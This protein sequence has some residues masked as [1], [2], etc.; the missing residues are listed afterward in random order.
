MQLLIFPTLL[1]ICA[2]WLTM[3]RLQ[4]GSFVAPADGPVAFRRD[5]LPLD[6]DTMADLSKHLGALA[7]GVGGERAEARRTAAQLLALALALEPG[8]TAARGLLETF[9]KGDPKPG[10][11][12]KQLESARARAWQVLGWLETAAADADEHALA[13]CLGDVMASVDPLHPHAEELRKLGEQGAWSNWVQPLDAFHKVETV[14]KNDP[15][16]KTPVRVPDGQ[17]SANSPILL[18]AA[19]VTTPLWTAD[20]S[21]GA[22]VMR[23]VPV[24]MS[25]KLKEGNAKAEPLSVAVGGAAATPGAGTAAPG[26]GAAAPGRGPAGLW[27][28]ATDPFKPIGDTLVKALDKELGKLPTGVSVALACGDNGDYLIERN[29]SAISGA[30]AVL[31]N[32]AI[33]GCEPNSTII[34]E[35]QADGS[36]KLPPQFWDKLRTLADGPGGRLVLPREAEK[37]LP[38]ILALEQA[39][40]FFKYEIL[41]AANL[42]E[43]IERTAKTPGPELASIAA[44]FLEVRSKLGS[45]AVTEYAANRFVRLRLEDL[46]RAASFHASARMLALQGAG[47]RPS[48]LPRNI[49]ADELRRVIRPMA[50][51]PT[52][53]V[54]TLQTKSLNDT[55]EACLRE[56]E[57]L[58]R[59]AEIHDREL[60]TQ[61]HDLVITVRTL[62]RATRG[63]YV[64]S[65]TQMVPWRA[66]Y[67]A[68][69]RSYQTVG[70]MLNQTAADG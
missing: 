2:G 18:A 37:Y 40:F 70:K 14:A 53:P 56:V 5:R 22:T 68:F 13:A 55:Y 57:R 7:Q 51:I 62:A 6:V 10:G 16:G 66:E 48:L 52:H 64:D 28:A 20:K 4:A 27:G 9:A 26:A 34:G 58:E 35:I 69:S 23:A 50:W 61:V 30:A 24:R 47:K 11:A 38:S 67:N 45:Q 59:Y 54:E 19:V 39:G 42:H 8:N 3:P 15:S 31:M 60:L 29:H 44:R 25:A 1:G 32:A 12:A 36:F 49:L 21:S 17:P 65:K 33:S 43:L 41:L 63:R 46:A